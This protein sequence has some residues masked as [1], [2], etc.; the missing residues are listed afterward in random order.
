MSSNHGALMGR[1]LVDEVEDVE[2]HVSPPG[3]RSLQGP[4]AWL[5]QE[6]HT[7]HEESLANY[8]VLF[9][10]MSSAA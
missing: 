5:L 6:Q 2:V 1:G 3:R 4:A 7:F 8:R 9:S 10:L